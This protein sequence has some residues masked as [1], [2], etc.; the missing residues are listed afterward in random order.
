MILAET[1]V[2][3]LPVTVV[4]RVG[5]FGSVKAFQETISNHTLEELFKFTLLTDGAV[6]RYSSAV[7][8]LRFKVR[9]AL[10]NERRNVLVRE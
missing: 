1:L 9:W 3:Y 4:V 5:A 10:L 6:Q 7:V 8:E 2:E